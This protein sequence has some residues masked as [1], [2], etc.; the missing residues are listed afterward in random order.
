MNEKRQLHI[1]IVDDDDDFLELVARELSETH[2]HRTSM[3][4][5]GQETIQLL[6]QATGRYDIILLDYSMR[7]L[8]GIGVLRWI[9]QHEVETPV[10][11][12]TGIGSEEIAV[13]AMKLGAYDYVRKENI[14]L[15]HLEVL[16]QATYE[17][18]L[19]RVTKAMEEEAKREM[20][21]G[22]EATENLRE[23]VKIIAQ[24]IDSSFASI[25]EEL[26]KGEGRIAH[27]QG[28]PHMDAQKIFQDLRREVAVLESGL[29]GFVKLYN[30]VHA[31][32]AWNEELEQIKREFFEKVKQQKVEK[33]RP[34]AA[35]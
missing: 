26:Q 13:E 23:V 35:Y 21:L 19:F 22:H 30:L 11:M 24:T 20:G 14:D 7:G 15:Q 28:R 5:S 2:G 4:R 3:A 10:I 17:R 34:P 16:L 29:Q 1:L 9:Q 27:T 12:L 32:H 31:H 33:G 18:H 6:E 25:T 8:D